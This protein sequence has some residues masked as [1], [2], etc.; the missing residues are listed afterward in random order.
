MHLLDEGTVGCCS[1]AAANPIMPVRILARLSACCAG[2][3]CWL[4]TWWRRMAACT[5]SSRC[6]FVVFLILPAAILP[7]SPSLKAER[8]AACAAAAA[9]AASAAAVAWRLPSSAKRL[10]C[11][12]SI[13]MFG[14]LLFLRMTSSKNLQHGTHL[15]SRPPV[16]GTNMA[17]VSVV[18]ESCCRA[19]SE[20]WPLSC[21]SFLYPL[22]CFSAV[23]PPHSWAGAHLLLL[24]SR[25][26]YWDLWCCASSSPREGDVRTV[27]CCSFLLAWLA[28]CKPAHEQGMRISDLQHQAPTQLSEWLQQP[29]QRSLRPTPSIPAVGRTCKLVFKPSSCC[30]IDSSTLA[31]KPG[32][33]LISAC[34]VRVSRCTP[35]LDSVGCRGSCAASNT[36][37]AQAGVPDTSTSQGRRSGYLQHAA[38]L[39]QPAGACSC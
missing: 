2:D 12:D 19:N 35:S 7:V 21:V 31:A 17:C 3:T 25:A 4:L 15:M 34:A 10:R 24:A 16:A 11:S 1:C 18:L 28:A 8:P 23:L 22:H 6:S 26:A 39:H 9:A 30:L 33:L 29:V 36:W 27:H 38:A 14:L 32:S 37:V 20:Q 13:S 5:A